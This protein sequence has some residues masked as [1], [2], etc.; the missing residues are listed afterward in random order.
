LK[1]K[2]FLA[3]FLN[4]QNHFISGTRTSIAF[5]RYLKKKNSKYFFWNM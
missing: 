4:F 3:P 1:K 2:I 5:I